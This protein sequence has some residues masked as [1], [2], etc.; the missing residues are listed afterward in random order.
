MKNKFLKIL[1][2]S[3]LNIFVCINAYSVEQFNFDVTEIEILEKGNVIKGLKKGKITTDKN[4]VIIANSFIYKKNENILEASGNVE[5][6]DIKKNIQIYSDKIIYL[7]NEER[8][9]TNG[10]SKAIYNEGI[11]ITAKIFDY[12]KNENILNARTQVKIDNKLENYRIFSE[13]ITYFKNDEKIISKGKTNAFIHSKY[14]IISKNINFNIKENLINSKNQTEIKDNNS[15]YYSLDNFNYHIDKEILKG[16]NILI[17]TNFNLPKSDKYYF[18][19]AIIDMK[20]QKFAG[21]DTKI[22]IHKSIF[23]NSEND[24]RLVG[25]SSLGNKSSTIINKGVFTSCKKRKDDK[26]PPWSISANQIKHDNK[27][28]Q[29]I[30]KNAF[31]NIYDLPVL[32]FLKFFSSIFFLISLYF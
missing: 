25:L 8:I 31:L 29:I 24:P 4:V 15:Q 20:N 12:R 18:S 2:L 21:K 16:E 13:D 11:I 9:K 30:Y 1:I 14:E 22:E 3:F 10:N 5:V 26:C 28:K 7:K 6:I 19:S 27:K 17:V 23:N 32:Y